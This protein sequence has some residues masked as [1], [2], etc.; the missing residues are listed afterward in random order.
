M[1]VMSDLLHA[2]LKTPWWRLRSVSTLVMAAFLAVS[3]GL[4]WGT[5]RVVDDQERRLLTER[6]GEISAILSNSVTTGLQASMTA[7]AT[8]AQASPAAFTLAAQAQTSAGTASAVALLTRQGD[9]WIV[10]AAAGDD[11]MTS[12][13]QV[14]RRV[15]GVRVPLFAAASTLLHSD[16]V[17]TPAGSRLALAVGPP[18]APPR[19]VIYEEYPLN[20]SRPLPVTSSQPFEE[21]SIAVYVGDKVDANKLLITTSP[22]TPLQGQ[23]RMSKVVVGD[24]SW[25]VVAKAK[26]PLA[27]VVNHALPLVLCLTSLLIGLVM[28]AMVELLSRRRDYAMSLVSERTH[29]LR[30]ARDQAMEASRQ[31]SQFLA[32]MSHEIR[33]PMNGVLGAA[34][35]LARTELEEEQRD[36]VAILSRSGRSLLAIIN[37]I[38]DISKIEAGRLETQDAPFTLLDPFTGVVE[39]LST[40][41]EAKGLRLT[42]VTSPDL[43]QMVIGD[44]VRL[45][46]VVTN[47]V[48]NAVKFTD[49]G[50]IVVDVKRDE[51]TPPPSNQVVV[52]CDVTDSGIGISKRDAEHLFK[53]FTQVDASNTRRFGGTGLGLA[54]SDRLV[55]LMGGEIGC[56]PNPS[57]GTTFWFTLPLTL[58]PRPDGRA[59]P[60]SDERTET[61]ETETTRTEPQLSEAEGLRA[62]VVDDNEVNAA[63]LT[64]MLGIIG[65]PCD[66]V[67][68]GTEAL[69]ALASRPYAMVLMDCQMPKMDGFAT[70]RQIR[71]QSVG[72]PRIPIIAITATATVEDEQKCLTAGMDDYLPKPI[73]MERLLAV[74]NRWVPLVRQ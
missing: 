10:Q 25:L 36:L 3:A 73:V 29:E 41:A 49:E 47:L 59:G 46:Q 61:T 48:G 57:G 52:R 7:L 37:N 6:T 66:T 8:A 50:S 70:T 15:A 65:Y 31:K 26:R 68:S 19:S 64:R 28:A 40:Q 43:P 32:N 34:D 22:R 9:G 33:T 45:G 56:R 1:S 44:A 12:G 2:R 69:A 72:Q 55:K 30:G 38:L 53:E 23:T 74:V 27:G 58:P 18:A 14:G 62:L 16:V 35:L 17:D 54:I 13:L 51:S 24:G 63:I 42:L 71:A 11:L 60:N 4:F 5:T 21:L 67:H 20:P 39:M